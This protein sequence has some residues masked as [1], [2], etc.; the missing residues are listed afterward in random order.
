[1][2]DRYGWLFASERFVAMT[3]VPASP[4]KFFAKSILLF[5]GIYLVYFSVTYVSFKRNVEEK[6]SG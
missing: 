6:L 3:G 2:G 4:L 5:F 1:M